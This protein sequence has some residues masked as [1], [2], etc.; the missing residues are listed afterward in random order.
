LLEVY[1][2]ALGYLGAEKR[3]VILICAANIALAAI[4]IAEPVLFGR[5]IDAISAKTEVVP[6]LSLWAAL[7]L[8]NIIAFVLVARGADRLA[9]SRRGAVLCESFERVIAMPL[10]LAPGARHIKRAAYAAA[11]RRNASSR[12]WLEF[13]RTSICRRRWR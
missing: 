1:W 3:K 6:T 7:G 4:T 11:R 13:M 9:H 5:V 12:L 10:V 8:F 2:R